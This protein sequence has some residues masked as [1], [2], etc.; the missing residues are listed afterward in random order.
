MRFLK[1]PT[2][3]PSTVAAGVLSAGHARALLSLET[4]EDTES[5]V[6]RLITE[7][8]NV[9]SV[10]ELFVLGDMEGGLAN[11]TSEERKT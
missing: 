8:L 9:L 7:R 1:L 3:M 4:P 11:E 10:E 6:D 5:M 2:A